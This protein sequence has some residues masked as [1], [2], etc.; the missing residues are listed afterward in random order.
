MFKQTEYCHV[1]NNEMKLKK[2]ESMPENCPACNADLRNPASENLKQ[3]IECQHLNENDKTEGAGELY[4]TNKRVFW[5]KGEVT[6]QS[7]GGEILVDEK[8]KI[9]RGLGRKEVITQ[10]TNSLSNIAVAGIAAKLKSRGA[11]QISF[12][13]PIDEVSGFEEWQKGLRK[14]VVLTGTDGEEH[15][16]LT[17]FAMEFMNTLS[18]YVR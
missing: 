13:L 11:G 4:I 8:T 18:R 3:T 7:L 16:F 15:I 2:N 6:A 17:P 14:G 5:M 12:E 9:K 1:C 10:K